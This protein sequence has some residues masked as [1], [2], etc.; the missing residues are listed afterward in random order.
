MRFNFQLAKLEG[1]YTNLRFDD[2]N[3]TKEK[4]EFIDKIQENMLWMGHKAK[5]VYFASD[6][7]PK[8]YDYAVQLIKLGKAF[9]CSLT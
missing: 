9:T 4:M 1:G 8:I 5:N 7:F 3:P 2:T 6:Y